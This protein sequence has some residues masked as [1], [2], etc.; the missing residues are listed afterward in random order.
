[1]DKIDLRLL[2]TQQALAENQI[3][4]EEFETEG[5]VTGEGGAQELLVTVQFSGEVSPLE[6]QG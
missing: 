6:T 5:V 1:M 2:M 3:G 4:E